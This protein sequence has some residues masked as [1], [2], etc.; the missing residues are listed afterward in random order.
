VIT[1]PPLRERP[2][3][4][5]LLVEHFRRRY[6]RE[7]KRFLGGRPRPPPPRMPGR[8]TCAS[9]SRRLERAVCLVDH[10]VIGPEDLPSTYGPGASAAARA[11]D[12]GPPGP[13]AGGGG[14][15][16]AHVLR[17][18]EYTR[19]NRRQGHGA[20]AASPGD[21]YRRLEEYG[22]HKRAPARAFDPRTALRPSNALLTGP[23]PEMPDAPQVGAAPGCNDLSSP[24]R[25]EVSSCS[26]ASC[27]ARARPSRR[28]CSDSP[29]AV[30]NL[31]ERGRPPT[32]ATTS[33]L[34][35]FKRTSDGYSGAF[36][37]N[38]SVT[39][40]SRG[41]ASSAASRGQLALPAAQLRPLGGRG[42]R[43]WRSRSRRSPKPAVG[44]C[45][46]A[47]AASVFRLVSAKSPLCPVERRHL[48]PR[49]RRR[50]HHFDYILTA[51]LN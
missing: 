17:A 48:L 32:A 1:V 26:P 50:P 46:A 9:C 28:V 33:G 37:C 8:S 4:V 35:Q 5:P 47:A 23:T 10:D 11:L 21:F 15:R 51:R 16:A 41:R 3:D 24:F 42:S 49:T 18:L 20:A 7:G 40:S 36:N 12:A 19:G 6:D 2:D 25:R 31:P 38:G 22:L 13:L 34:V 44:Q 29:T 45:P 30:T 43:R 14:G 39:S 27:S